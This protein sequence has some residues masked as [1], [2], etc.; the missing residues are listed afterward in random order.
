MKV[1]KIHIEIKTLDDTLREVG[2][3]YETISKG[4]HTFP[5]IY[6]AGWWM[7]K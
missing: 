4:K 1:K 3:T 2:K 5:R 6:T 7:L